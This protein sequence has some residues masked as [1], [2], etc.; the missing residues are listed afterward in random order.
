[1]FGVTEEYIQGGQLRCSEHIYVHIQ[2]RKLMVKNNLSVVSN[3]IIIP[4]QIICLSEINNKQIYRALFLSWCKRILHLDEIKH[5]I[6]AQGLFWSNKFSKF[7][8]K[9]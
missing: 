8:E 1:M 4:N 6:Q 3:F 2:K 7:V 9:E 5:F